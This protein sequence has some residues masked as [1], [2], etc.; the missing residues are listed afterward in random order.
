MTNK[1]PLFKRRWIEFLKDVKRETWIFLIEIGLMIIIC[2]LHSL[3]EGQYV[4]FWPINGTFQNFNPV[5][6][7]LSGQVPYHDFED[8]LG[9]GHLYAGSITTVI[10]GG[11]YRGSLIAFSFLS[12][13]G[14]ALLSF[15]ISMAVCEKKDV[16]GAITNIFLIVLLVQPL[17]YTNT[18]VGT[19]D[20]L[21]ALNSALSSG[22]SA[23]FVRGMILPI[24]C[25]LISVGYNL[26]DFLASRNKFFMRK[27]ECFFYGGV[28]LV[29]GF[30]FAW[31]NDYGISC[32][33]CF[34]IMAFWV[35]ICRTK[36]LF[37]S[38]GNM[39]MEIMCSI[40]SLAITVAI[41]S[42][43]NIGKWIFATFGT[44]GYQRWYYNSPKSSYLFD[45]DFSYIMLIQAGLTMIYLIRLFRAGGS[46]N[47]IKHDGI[48]AFVNITCFCAVN[49]YQLLSGGENREVALSTLF[50]TVIYELGC[51]I[52][53]RYDKY[54]VRNGVICCSL[55]LGMSWSVSTFKDEVVSYLFEDKSGVYVEALGGNLTNLGDDLLNTNEFLAGEKFFATY[56]SAQEVVSNI[57]QPSGTDYI[58]HVLGDRQREDYLNDFCIFRLMRPV[59]TVI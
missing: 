27:R 29:A 20:I 1:Y 3:S 13:A 16:A 47:S 55:L 48:L 26:Y 23:R 6:R 44:G 14:I 51:N 8:Y 7:L 25:I 24:S 12:F 45:V 18:L 32:W 42:K 57:Y 21:N 9:M 53:K 17:V 35:S 36:K 49:E 41:F 5:R 34:I 4:N 22:N 43:G 56:A 52:C 28:G 46:R 30:C 15:V 58:I 38:L 19:N 50:L 33:V 10:F 59:C 39:L 40:I 54:S 2:V 11:N 31:S 37:L